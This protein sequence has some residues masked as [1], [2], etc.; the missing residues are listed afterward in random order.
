MPNGCDD[1]QPNRYNGHPY[2]LLDHLLHVGDQILPVPGV[3]ATRQ[4]R[5]NTQY[6]D[7]DLAT[8]VI[9]LQRDQHHSDFHHLVPWNCFENGKLGSFDVEGEIVNSW[10]SH[11]QEDSVQ[12]HT[13]EKYLN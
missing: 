4:V 13:L 1:T 3:N 11:C 6:A 10:I 2:R 8:I 7:V 5:L 9:V 12:R